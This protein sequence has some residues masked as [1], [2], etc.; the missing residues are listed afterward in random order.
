MKP[1]AEEPA[2]FEWGRFDNHKGA[3]IRYG[4]MPAEGTPKATL[5]ITPGFRE[6][7]EKYFEVV[8]EMHAQGYDIWLMDWRGQGG[9]DRYIK[10]SH[11]A[12][13]EGYDEQIETLHIFTQQVVKKTDSAPFVFM[14]HSMGAHIGLRYLSEHDG[15]FDA[16][17]LTAPMVDIQTQG[18][19]KT[20]A[21]QMAKFAKAGNYL[22]RYVPGG[23]DWVD[24]KPSFSENICTSDIERFGVMPELFRRNEN[25]QIGD[26]TYGWVFHTFASI[27]ILNQEAYLKKIKTPVLMQVSGDE[28]VVVRA[29]QE[30]A[31]SLMQDCKSVLIPEAMHE[32]WMERDVYRG[33]WLRE[34]LEFMKNKVEVAAKPSPKKFPSHEKPIPPA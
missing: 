23:H 25:L 30:R 31:A 15:I 29:A 24:G 1:E 7:V 18:L 28:K 22:D 10:N 34:V 13:H 4:Y 3:S 6:P 16:A 27:D 21:R 9:S 17:I 5:V 26:P 2:G 33:A 8:R 11:K 20:L 32:I 12:H 14:G 19:P